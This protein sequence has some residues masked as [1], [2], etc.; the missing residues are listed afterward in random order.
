[1]AAEVIRTSLTEFEK[2]FAG[3]PTPDDVSV[4]ADGRRLDS[5]EAVLAWW[6]EVGPEIEAEEAAK[7]GDGG[8][9]QP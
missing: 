3:R 6:A 1:V 9:D 2:G 7:V 8:A 5:K 4:T